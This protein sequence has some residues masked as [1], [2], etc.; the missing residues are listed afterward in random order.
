MKTLA[1]VTPA[2]KLFPKLFDADWR[3]TQ[4]LDLPDITIEFITDLTA[5]GIQ[6]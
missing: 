2:H 6:V 3:T 4:E 5:Y 1:P